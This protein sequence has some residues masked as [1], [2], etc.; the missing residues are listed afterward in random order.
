MLVVRDPE[1]IKRI[2]VKDFDHFVNHKSLLNEEAAPLLAKGITALQGQSWREMRSI[3]S[4]SFTGSKMRTMLSLLSENCEQLVDYFEKGTSEVVE[5][6]MK[7][8]F[9]RF[10]N[11]AIASVAFGLKCDSLKER[12]NEFYMMGKALM[13]PG[14]ITLLK[15]VAIMVL[16]AVSKVSSQLNTIIPCHT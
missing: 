9:T 4:P 7:D 8:A 3:L 14:I 5:T 13:S 11:D 10:T 6:D 2:T 15:A 12:E 16:P 1:L